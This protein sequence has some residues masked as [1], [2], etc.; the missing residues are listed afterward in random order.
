M[1]E[2][3]H[4]DTKAAAFR[5]IDVE[6]LI[7]SKN[8]NL[9]RLIPRF[10]INYLKR[11]IH[12]DEINAAITQNQDKIGL[13]FIDKILEIFGVNVET[14]GIENLDI[15]GRYLIAS[16]HP[17]GGLDGMALM[18]VAGAV[19]PNIVFPVNDLLMNLPNLAPLF[20]PVNK[21]GSNSQNV[22][23]MD[24][25]F[26]SDKWMLYFPAGLCSRKQHGKIY[27]LEWKKSFISKA[28]KHKRDIIPTYIDGKNS[29][30][31]YNLA[32]I[33]KMLGIKANIEMLYLPDEMF[34]Q[35]SK[36]IRIT[37]GKPIPWQTFDKRHTDAE[38]AGIMKEHVYAIGN[39][40]DNF[41]ALINKGKS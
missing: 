14:A 11:T 29:D 1:T 17:L 5:E 19:N 10:V 12:Q 15:N 25:T 38:W 35:N 37:F 18:K 16:N 4:T 39:S 33:R 8:R 9:A 6:S 31:F 27:D 22:K 21:H 7:A 23:I 28:S 32:N 26:A 30:F 24:E 20:I 36:T 40:I 2:L 3:K 13:S 41:E 34:N